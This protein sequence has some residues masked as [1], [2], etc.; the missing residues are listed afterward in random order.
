MSLRPVEATLLAKELERELPGAVVQQL[1]SPSAT[2]VYVEL[3]IPGRSVVVLVCCDVKSSRLSVVEKRP[4]NP[5]EPPAWQSVL[6][7]ELVGAR[8]ADVESVEARRLLL[9][10]FTAERDGTPHARTLV[11]EYGDAPGIALT[12]KE[13]R[14][15]AHSHPFREGIRHGSTWTPPD[16]SPVREAPSRLASDFVQLRLG[17]GAEALFGAQEEERWL[18]AR[19]APLEAKLKK[20]E[21]TREKVRAETN[22]TAQAETYKQEGELLAQNLYRLTRGD[23]AVVLP[24]YRADGE[25]VER[26]IPLDPARTPKQEV[27]WRFHQY[28]RLLRGVEFATKRLAQLDVEEAKLRAELDRLAATPVDAPTASRK[29]PRQQDVAMAPFKAYRGHQDHLIWV[30]RGSAHNDALTFQIARPWHVWFHVRG[31]PGAHVVVPV[32]K[33]GSL[34]PEVLLDAAH[35]AL[36]HSDLKGEPR[37]EVSY[38]P[39][40]RVRKAKGGAPGAVTYTGEKTL[41]LR[42]EPQRLERLLATETLGPLD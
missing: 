13:G 12:T 7:R 34:L 4:A 30:G 2:R 26:S 40:K 8:L 21:R 24:E 10:H 35:L 18:K 42:V 38:V 31:S 11:L 19:L 37:G 39:V 28:R 25:V 27:E 33:N 22:R 36:H 17:H 14:V 23:R 16:E 9:L 32:A 29:S 41:M 5:A 6:R 15:L 3:R 1:S 20:L